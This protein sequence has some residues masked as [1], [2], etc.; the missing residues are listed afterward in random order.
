MFHWKTSQK[1]APESLPS[2]KVNGAK[3]GHQGGI[4]SLVNES[5]EPSS[6]KEKSL[7]IANVPE[8]KAPEP[9]G[10][11]RVLVLDKRVSTISDVQ[12]GETKRQKKK[13]AA[14]VYVRGKSERARKLAASH[15]SPFKGNI[16]AKLIIPNKPVGPRYDPFAP[17]DKKMS[18]VLTDRL[19]LYP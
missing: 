6:S 10:E 8:Y 2:E 1:T 7:E 15:Q 17:A 5:T 19:K 18:K 14:M 16:T 13:D 11:P 4:G 3:A 12:Q 9:S